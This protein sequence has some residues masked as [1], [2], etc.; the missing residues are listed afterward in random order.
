[1]LLGKINPWPD[2]WGLYAFPPKN[3]QVFT[4]DLLIETKINPTTGEILA[5]MFQFA[6]ITFYLLLG[7]PDNEE[8][9]GIYRPRGLIFE[10]G[11]DEHRIEFTWPFVTNQAVTYTNVGSTKNNPPHREGWKD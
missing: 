6:G 5:A 7:R 3:Q 10:H 11:K 4:A 9:F 8:S 1:M 2:R